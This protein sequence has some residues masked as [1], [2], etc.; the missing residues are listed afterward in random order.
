[1]NTTK[2]IT[3]TPAEIEIL[4]LEAEHERELVKASGIRGIPMLL[5][6]ARLQFAEEVNRGNMWNTIRAH[7]FAAAIRR[8]L[9]KF[10]G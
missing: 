7:R 6:E 10:E 3:F 9:N 2:H 8:H 5:Q 4:R 1:M